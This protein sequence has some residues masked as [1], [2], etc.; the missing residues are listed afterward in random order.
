MDSIIFFEIV[1]SM[2]NAR[3][4]VSRESHFAA[5]YSSLFPLVKPLPLPPTVEE[6]ES[7]KYGEQE[8]V[9]AETSLGST[10]RT[11]HDFYPESQ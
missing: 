10:G 7:E 3:T 9:R 2:R 6:F 8:G 11:N 1:S 4:V 5:L